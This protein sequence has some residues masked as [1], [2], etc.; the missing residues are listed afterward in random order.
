MNCI[1]VANYA[2][3]NT[4]F[5]VGTKKDDVKSKLQNFKDTFPHWLNPIQRKL[6]P[7]ICHFICSS[8]VNCY[9]EKQK[10]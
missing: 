8:N 2:D 1:D 10:N 5:F 3:D 6:K 9:I 4:P 7:G